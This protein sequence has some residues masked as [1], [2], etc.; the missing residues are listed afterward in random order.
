[1]LGPVVAEFGSIEREAKARVPS[2]HPPKPGDVVKVSYD[3]KN[4]KTEIQVK[5]DPRYDPRLRRANAKQQRAAEVEALLHG[6]P[7]AL[8]DDE[9]QSPVPEDY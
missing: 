9:P 1:M 4:H 3:P 2:L 6:A 8:V 5:G 7:A